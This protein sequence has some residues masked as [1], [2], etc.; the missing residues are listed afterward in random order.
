MIKLKPLYNEIKIVN[1]ITPKMVDD[2]ALNM[3]YQND[4]MD[5]KI[6][7]ILQKYGWNTSKTGREWVQNLSDNKVIKN[8]YNDLIQLKQQNNLS[9]IKIVPKVTPEI[10][11]NLYI[12]KSKI[13]DT[14]VSVL[15]ILDDYGFYQFSGTE[16]HGFP[17]WEEK[18]MEKYDGEVSG[19][20]D[21]EVFDFF[22]TLYQKRPSQLLLLYQDLLKIK[23]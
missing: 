5:V 14:S 3:V 4:E 20:I 6:M 16:E 1:K 18:I 17:E 7:H 9:E 22:E 13:N 15:G 12:E 10:V 8:L 19:Y 23:N 2:L 11:L 21:H